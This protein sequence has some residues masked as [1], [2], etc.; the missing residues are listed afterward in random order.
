MNLFLHYRKETR[1]NQERDWAREEKKRKK[2]EREK[3]YPLECS[4]I[5]FITNQEQLKKVID[6]SY[7]NVVYILPRVL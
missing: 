5:Y 6:E 1:Q 4:S 7:G 2:R 3:S